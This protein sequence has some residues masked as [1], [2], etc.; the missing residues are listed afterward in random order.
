M[1]KDLII[2]N[3]DRPRDAYL[4]EALLSFGVLV[5]FMS[6][7]IFFYKTKPHIPMLFGVMIASLIALKIG[8]KWEQVQSSIFE[9]ITQAI[10]A[11]VILMLVGVLIGTWVLSGVVPS[12]IFYGLE[13]LTPSIFLVATVLVCSV[14]SLATGTSWATAGTMGIA[15]IGI[16]QALGIPTSITAGAIISG[17]Y[18][19]DKMSP[20][21]DTTNLAPA[22]SGTGL[23]THIKF[24][25]L[26]TFI[27]YVITL[28]FFAYLS[29]KFHANISNVA[30][31]ETL[32][33]AIF[34]QF[35]VS[36]FLLLPP[37]IVL[38]SISFRVPSV[39][40]ISLGIIAACLLAPIFQ[41]TNLGEILHVSMNG[42]SFHSGI[43]AIDKLL[44]SGGL[45]NMMSAVSLAILAMMFGGLMERTGQLEVLVNALLKYVKSVQGLLA[46]TM[47]TCLLSNVSMP[48]QYISVIIPGR[49]FA[50][51]YKQKKLHPKTLSNA[52]E[53]S[54]TLSSVL[55]PWNT[56][57]IFMATVLGVSTIDYLWYCIFNLSMPFVVL[58][59]SFLGKGVAYE[60]NKE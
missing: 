53:S 38:L 47:G 17:A 9:G 52:I 2:E 32:K 42:F 41:E 37:L 26:P 28:L 5:L 23:F 45:I 4:Y 56:C 58:A 3:K 16:S 29:L 15:L 27:A 39:V 55:I 19:G 6:I 49:M 33:I 30:T 31:L 46:T 43:T 35:S 14:T 21:S 51:I 12:M 57:G 7:S 18:F 20:L 22:V 60:K 36:P 1:D 50:P 34:S 59:L 11:I 48:E 8:Y 54:G 25:M 44:S 10:K 13:F 24:M 40:G